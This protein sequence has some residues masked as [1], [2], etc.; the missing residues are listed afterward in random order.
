MVA[1]LEGGKRN[2]AGEAS[3]VRLAPAP[4]EAL[5]QDITSSKA[6]TVVAGDWWIIS[7]TE[8]CFIATH[9][10]AAT[11]SAS[12][13]PLPAGVHDFVIPDGVTSLALFSSVAGALG[14][15]WRG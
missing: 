8:A 4:G 9:A 7:S 10:T 13:T 14:A 1:T 5:A 3:H 6:F 12:T 11:A 2:G 15:A